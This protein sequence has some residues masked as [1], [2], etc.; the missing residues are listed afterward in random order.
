MK[1]IRI[2]RFALLAMGIL[3]L[4]YCAAV[5]LEARLYQAA[6]AGKFARELRAGR[7]A[8]AVQGGTPAV[9]RDGDVIGRLQ[10]PR[11]GLSVM[12]VEGV[13][14]GD[15]RRAAGHIPGT[16]APGE[17]GNIAIAAHRDTFFRPLCR[18]R[19]GDTI[20]LRTLAGAWRYRVAS[21]RVVRPEDIAVLYPTRR[22]NLTLITC[23][24][25]DYIGA[26]PERFV[27]RA[28]RLAE[29][30]AEAKRAGAAG[31]QPGGGAG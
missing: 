11:V 12:V 25:F 1:A 24:P 15:L 16:A 28:E 3:A 20:T 21:L 8:P 30:C 18:L 19:P 26:A 22:D 9:P 10:I 13:N 17:P 7:K 4:G 6:Q 29:T 5:F 23:Y 27:V 2:T 31:R 14:A